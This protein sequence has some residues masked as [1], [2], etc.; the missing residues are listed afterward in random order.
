MKKAI[1]MI[2][3]AGIAGT[4]IAI[5]IILAPAIAIAQRSKA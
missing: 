3:V 5:R 1:T 2:V 4:L